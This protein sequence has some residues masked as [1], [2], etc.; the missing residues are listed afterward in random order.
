ML[1]YYKL[2]GWLS[3]MKMVQCNIKCVQEKC[4]HNTNKTKR[5]TFTGSE[6]N[7]SKI[8]LKNQNKTNQT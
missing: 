8:K 3:K 7:S 1:K 4:Q 2:K 5:L 6:R